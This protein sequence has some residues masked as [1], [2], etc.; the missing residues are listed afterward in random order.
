MTANTPKVSIGLP[1]YNGER[2]LAGALDGILRQS[3]KDFEVVISDN[4]STDRTHEICAEYCKR[5]KRIRYSRNETNIGAARNFNRAFELS[6]GSYFAWFAYDDLYDDRYL[7]LCVKVLDEDA[8][9]SLCHSRV[10]LIDE[11]GAPIATTGPDRKIGP[12]GR[13]VRHSDKYHIAES[14]R[15]EERF[16]DVLH[17]VSW[18]LQV[19]GLLRTENLRQTGLQRNY[20]GA[21][22]V[23]LAEISLMGRFHQIDETLFFKRVHGAMTFY[24]ST[25]SKKKWID[26]DGARP[27]P[28]V[29]MLKDYAAMVMKT[30]MPLRARLVCLFWIAAMVKRPGL[31]HKIFVPGPYNYLG[32]NFSQKKS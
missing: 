4:A 26:P 6:R 8:G 13:P 23:F 29:Q 5:D 22:K 31:W 25:D 9:V 24:M 3:F 19:F 1:V 28:Q 27:L 10:G 7:E 16:K 18:C 17:N 2:Y 15:I 12:D 30:R 20:Y 11:S 21:D 32:I 14:P